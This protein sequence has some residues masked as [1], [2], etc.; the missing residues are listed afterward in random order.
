MRLELAR[1]GV[2]AQIVIVNDSRANNDEDRNQLISRT[3]L[4][5]FQDTSYKSVWTALVA[6]KDDMMIYDRA[7]KLVQYIPHKGAVPSI[8][9]TPEGYA[10]VKN[11]LVTAA[12]APAKP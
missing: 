2:Q 7:G 1:E 6:A 9:S 3:R 5:L 12:N 4:P 10:A 8:L 11:A